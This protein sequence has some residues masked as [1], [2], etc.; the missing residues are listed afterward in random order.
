MIVAN[1]AG[2]RGLTANAALPYDENWS[3]VIGRWPL[4][5]RLLGALYRADRIEKANDQGPTTND[6]FPMRIAYLDCFSGMSGDMF[7]GALVDAGVPAKLFEETVAALNIG[8]R[9]EISRV[10]RSG[11]TATKV[12]VFVHGEKELPR[13]VFFEQQSRAQKHEHRHD[14]GHATSMRLSM[15]NFANTIT[16]SPDMKARGRGRPRH[17]ARHEH[18]RGLKEIREII[19]KAGISE[20]RSAPRSPF[21]KRWARRK[22]RSTTT[23]SKECTSTKSA[24]WTRWWISSAPPWEPKR[25]EWMRSC[26]PR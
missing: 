6:G 2:L 5:Q 22:P 9:L 10:N 12:D 24:Q 8:A 26:A 25:W 17:T 14:H 19:R 11:I 15:L 4:A 21:S 18:G 16:V 13:E 1:R 3:L 23:T 20:A 7:L